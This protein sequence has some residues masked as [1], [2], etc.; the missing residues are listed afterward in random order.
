MYEE[1]LSVLS[2]DMAEFIKNE[3]QCRIEKYGLKGKSPKA[4]KGC[5]YRNTSET[6]THACCMFADIPADWEI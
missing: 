3:C 5:K 4:C 2:K 6:N 1:L